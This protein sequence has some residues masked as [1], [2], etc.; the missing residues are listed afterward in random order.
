MVAL[1]LVSLS[2]KRDLSRER[3]QHSRLVPY[4]Y[5]IARRWKPEAGGARP[6]L[7][8]TLARMP[9]SERVVSLSLVSLSLKRDLSR[10]EANN[11]G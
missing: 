1:S 2:L 6:S 11:L 5:L 8:T 3:G 9:N 10:E 4:D 7:S